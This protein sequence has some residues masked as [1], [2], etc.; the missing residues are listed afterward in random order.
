M[1][2]RSLSLIGC[3]LLCGC[4]PELCN[5]E[6]GRE[7]AVRVAREY[8]LTRSIAQLELGLPFER[9]EAKRIRAAGIS[10]KI[11]RQIFQLAEPDRARRVGNQL[12][13]HPHIYYQAIKSLVYDGFDVSFWRVIP[14]DNPKRWRVAVVSINITKCGK[15]GQLFGISTADMFSKKDNY[16]Q[17]QRGMGFDICH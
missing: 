13:G 14:N 2:P 16:G 4:A 7:T 17:W 5:N 10:E 9:A 12:C 6:I 3:L 11:Y 1:T 8:F 15:I